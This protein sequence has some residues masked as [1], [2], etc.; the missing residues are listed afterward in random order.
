V[1]NGISFLQSLGKI[2]TPNWVRG[3]KEPRSIMKYFNRQVPVS[4]ENYIPQC[5]GFREVGRIVH[6][7]VM[8]VG[9]ATSREQPSDV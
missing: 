6:A 5:A 8:I 2:F 3:L 7:S 9:T 1:F 4:S